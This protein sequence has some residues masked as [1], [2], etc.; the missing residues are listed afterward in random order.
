MLRRLLA[1]VAL[2]LLT[3]VPAL[4]QVTPMPVPVQTFFAANG[5]V[6]NACTLETYEAGTST[7]LATYQDA[8]STTPHANPV[9]MSSVGKPNTGTPIYLLPTFYKFILKS[10]AGATIWTADNITAVP[11]TVTGVSNATDLSLQVDTDNNG[12]NKFTFLNGTLVEKA[13]IDEDGDAQFDGNVTVGD[14]T[15]ADKAV[16]FDGNTQDFHAGIDD[17]ADAFIIGRGTSLG[18]TP[19]ITVSSA[20]A[21]TVDGA[22]SFTG[23][24]SVPVGGAGG[25]INPAGIVNFDDT[26]SATGANTT[27]T[28]LKTYTAPA[29]TLNVNG[30]TLRLV[31]VGSYAANTNNKTIRIRFGG[32]GGT[33]VVAQT[34]TG[35]ADRT[36]WRV[37]GVMSRIASNSQRV[38]GTA[39]FTDTGDA[40]D[41][42]VSDWT[43][44]AQTDSGAIDLVVTGQNGTAAASDI[45]FEAAW[46]YVY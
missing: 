25:S 8:A 38:E 43:A 2:V 5:D 46:V 37:E 26:Q 27:E 11:A 24:V 20:G 32:I 42:Q 34:V 45:V 36:R 3:A 10:S 6:C 17:S 12:S 1:A 22:T 7:P 14:A 4:C 44:S 29:N 18:T 33:V 13:Q 31:A 9:V 28:V 40:L 35:Q 39:L 30:R 19:A 23:I 21:V 16:L 15:E 41:T